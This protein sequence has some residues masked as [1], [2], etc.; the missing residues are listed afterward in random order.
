M[1][2]L[3]VL[4]MAERRGGGVLTLEKVVESEQEK[5]KGRDNT[6]VNKQEHF[7]ISLLP[8]GFWI[9]GGG[10]NKTI[11]AFSITFREGG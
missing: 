10:V 9:G 8:L 3:R 7:L 5:Q 11:L 4:V 1:L 2:P 6:Q